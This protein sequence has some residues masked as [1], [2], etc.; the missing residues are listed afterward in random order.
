MDWVQSIATLNKNNQGF[1]LITVLNVLGSAPREVG[2]KMV[3]THNETFDTIGGGNL[4]YQAIAKARVLLDEGEHR[5]FRES[6]SLG[7]DLTQCCGGKVELLFECIPSCKIQIALFGAGHVGTCLSKIL[8]ELPYRVSWLDNRESLISEII[9]QDHADSLD[10]QLFSQPETMVDKFPKNTV[11]LVLTHS[12][13]LDMELVEAI[14]SR[15]DARFCGLIGSKSKAGKFRNRLRKKGFTDDEIKPLVCPVGLSNVVG[16]KPMEVAVSIAAQ[17]I[18]LAY[19]IEDDNRQE[20]VSSFQGK[21][22]VA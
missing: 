9:S 7:K 18:G 14:I 12:H 16:K 5:V 15:G 2:A 1:V 6:F 13:E 8:S 20:S 19:E 22:V 4:E 17:I 11:F 21:S 3:I 10:V